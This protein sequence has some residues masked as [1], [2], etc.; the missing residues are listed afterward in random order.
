M[1]E[2]NSE[3]FLSLFK[4]Y[5]D[6]MPVSV[7]L[8]QVVEMIRSDAALREHTEKCRYYRTLGNKRSAD[9]EKSSCPCFSVAVGFE[10]GRQKRHIQRWTALSMVDLDH[11]ESGSMAELF[12]R[13]CADPHTLLAYIT[14]SGEGMHVLYRVDNIQVGDSGNDGPNLKNYPIAYG[15]GSQYYSSLLGVEC[16]NQCKNVT[17]LSGMA[18][19]PNVYYNPQAIVLPI[20]M[21]EVKK[22]GRPSNAR[23][24][25]LE[26]VT[27]AV[28]HELAQQ[29][30]VYEPGHHNEYI[31]RFAYLLNLYGV[32]EVDASVF[33]CVR[34][35]DYGM[36]KVSAIVESCYK[37]TEEHGTRKLKAEDGKFASVSE[38]EKFLTSQGQFRQNEITGE[39]EMYRSSTD[40]WISMEDRDIN[41]CWARMSKQVKPVRL[42]DIWNVLHSEFVPM[43]N[44]FQS[45][46]DTLPPW[47]ESQPDYIGMLADTVHTTA[48]RERFRECFR[49]W[50]VGILPTLFDSVTNQ[51]IFVLIGNQGIYKTSW[52]NHLLPPPLRRYYYT[53]TNSSRMTKDDQLTLAEFSLVNFE[54]I[55]SMRPSELNQLKALIT[56]D[57]INERPAYARAKVHRPHIASFCGTGNNIAFLTDPTGNRRWLPFE[58]KSIENPFEYTVNY[59]GVYSQALYLWK[60]GFNYW[61]SLDEIKELNRENTY[62]EVPSM[63][64]ELIQTYYRLPAEGEIGIFKTAT[65]ILERIN[66]SIK[67]P[68]S[69][70]RI[71]HVMKKLEFPSV[72][73]KHRRGYIVVERMI[74]EIHR[75]EEATAAILQKETA[76]EKV[77][78][79]RNDS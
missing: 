39:V 9:K 78:D 24:T 49:K 3:S 56:L 59:S 18:F 28:I 38:I 5:T 30:I 2:I 57:A 1:E 77:T 25:S 68:L 11:L 64:E 21:P 53:K 15:Q 32:P 67:H 69:I 36:E 4:G 75:G 47:D 12:A 72:R 27:S 37:N 17:R 76:T 16:D 40:D 29:H 45:Y 55:D 33:L 23:C 20:I 50:F 26:L 22:S 43:F 61:F 79:D 54:E 62:F 44:P 74:D 13:V 6:T 60:K 14:V 34:C 8:S 10:G 51:V 41:T 19:D 46:L 71:G 65:E 31:M 35:A 48:T 66:S 73:G 52:L 70:Q 58:V 42:N 63:E 7:S